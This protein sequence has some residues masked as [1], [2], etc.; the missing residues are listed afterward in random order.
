MIHRHDMTDTTLDKAASYNESFYEDMWRRMA[1]HSPDRLPW[2][3]ALKELADAS[4]DR[5]E[6]GPGVFP[7]LPV[8]GTHAVDLSAGALDVLAKHGAIVHHG[9]LQDL[10]FPDGSFDL[11]GMFELLEHVQ[12]DEGLLREVARLTRPGGRLVLTVPL[13]M[14]HYCSFDRY[15]GHVRRFEPDELKTKVERAGYV[16]ER[17]EIHAQSIHEPLASLYVAVMRYFPRITAWS[18][19]YIFLP[20]LARK[21]IEWRDAPQ[22][23]T[24][25]KGATDC[26]AIFRRL[27]TGDSPG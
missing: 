14:K 3:P 4:P 2:W 16:L 26:G 19:R 15:M 9:L 10:K 18:L 23:E 24:L 12:D 25:S 27:G 5:L 17:F 7:R 11:V 20:L 21:R 6:L 8:A 13:G 22:W 1:F